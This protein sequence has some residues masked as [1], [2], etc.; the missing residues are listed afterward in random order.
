VWLERVGDDDDDMLAGDLDMVNV[1]GIMD[2]FA[3]PLT[4]TV[5]DNLAND[6]ALNFLDDIQPYLSTA[7]SFT[8]ITVTD[9]RTEGAPQFSSQ[10][11]FPV[12]GTDVSG[13]MPN[14]VAALTTW[15]TAL[16][17]RSGRG[18]SYW[19]GWGLDT[20]DGNTMLGVPN[21][22]LDEMADDIVGAG[23]FGVIS[24]FHLNAKRA[25]GIITPIT[26][27]LTSLEWKSQRG[28][29]PSN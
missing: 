2:S 27:K 3:S 13:F 24:R 17:S 19:S 26:G 14:E 1:F 23:Y 4:Q 11:N 8:G 15:T 16:R 9:L 18:R 20:T 29:R 21:A 6:M 25:T 28:R 12:T 7:T 10:S 5:A 22:A